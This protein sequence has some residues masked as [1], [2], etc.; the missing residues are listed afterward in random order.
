MK[1]IAFLI[2][3]FISLSI[4]L[5]GQDKPFPQNIDY[6]YGYQ[7]TVISSDHVDS[8][9]Q[10]FK[11][12][13]LASCNG[14]GSVYRRVRCHGESDTETRSEG[15]GYGMILAAYFADQGVFDSLFL[16][17]RDKRHE[18]ALHLM[19]WSVTCTGEWDVGCA[20]DGDIDVAY[21]LLVAEDQWGGEGYLDSARAILAILKDSGF[22]V[23]DCGGGWVM[24]PGYSRYGG[25]FW[26]GCSLTDL[27]YYP[28]AFFRVFADAT[29]DGFW[30]YVAD[31]VYELY[32]SAAHPTTGLVPNW[33]S[34]DGVPGGTKT[35]EP[36]RDSTYHYDASR[37]PWRLVMDYIWNGNSNAQAAC[38]KISDFAYGIRPSKILDGYYINGDSLGEWNNGAFVG[39]FTVGGM[40]HSQ[41]MLDSFA[42]RLYWLDQQYWDNQYYNLSLK[43]IYEVVMTGNFWKPEM[44][45]GIEEPGFPQEGLKLA[46]NYPNPFGGATTIEYSLSSAGFVQLAIYD[47]SGREVKT[48]VE[49]SV[50][51]GEHEVSVDM[52]NLSPGVYIYRLEAEGNSLQK[53]MVLLR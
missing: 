12:T 34:W 30:D 42:T 13:L 29:G 45:S 1:N 40:A 33:H 39:G 24:Q 6:P 51:A 25:Q 36:D 20:T 27:S 28:P 22:F 44:P 15:M 2:V 8:L 35:T 53:K 7:T 19:S 31:D 11:D 50:S 43:L 9:Y 18:R 37:I 17:Y 46:Q 38:E 14:P 16:F 48:L 32:D 52:G 3:L 49:E 26:G 21:A 41:E 5:L 23:N 47:I 10:R 4:Y